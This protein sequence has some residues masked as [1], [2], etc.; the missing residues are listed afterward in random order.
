MLTSHVP[1]IQLRGLSS[2]RWFLLLAGTVLSL[3]VYYLNYGAE[4]DEGETAG[5]NAATLLT[6]AVAVA[7]MVAALCPLRFKLG[8]AMLL[9]LLWLASFV[10]ML[11]AIGAWGGINDSLFFNTVL[12]VP[13]LIALTS[14]RWHVDYVRWLRFIAVVLALQ[15][16]FDMA[17]WWSDTS[18][19]LSAAFVGGVGNPSSFG[20]LCS[21]LFAFCLLHPKAG[22]GRWVLALT[23]GVAAVM[24]KAL[25]AVLAVTI[26][27][28]AWLA[29]SW[30]RAAVGAFAIAVAAVL[31]LAILEGDDTEGVGFVAHKLS[32]AGALIGLLEY[33]IDT[34]ASVSMRLEMHQETMS[35]I[36]KQPTRLLWGHLEGKPYWPMDSQV[37][38]YL[39]SFGAPMLL[40]FIALN[41]WWLAL[42]WRLRRHD[43]AFSIW[44]LG[45]FSLI[46]LTN[47]VL[48]YF[49]VAT[50]YFLLVTLALQ[51]SYY[52]G[53]KRQ[54]AVTRVN[55]QTAASRA[56]SSAP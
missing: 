56:Q 54:R 48:D 16:L 18:L 41:L 21:V 49:P 23:L 25:F 42:A 1:P 10:S 4:F 30:R 33:D 28:A 9:T 24:S 22:R 47:R 40:A 51:E 27:S 15:A 13:V 50:L 37:L 34:S 35:A 32:A 44:S 2:P 3:S 11:I 53:R 31:G 46:F 7:L 39:G 26:V 45:L 43:G 6:R 19:W 52:I 5:G 17:I 14:T 29:H 8:G 12:Q 38:T 55:V 36:A 20:M